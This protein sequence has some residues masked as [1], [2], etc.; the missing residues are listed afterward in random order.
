MRAFL[1][2]I[3][4]W[5]SSK[6]VDLMDAHEERG[7]LR[8]LLRAATETDCGLP[9]DDSQLA[10]F[11]K[12]GAQWFKPTKEK[13]FRLGEKTSGQKLR[14]C[15]F[16]RDG[17]LFNERLLKEWEYQ[18]SISEKRSKASAAGNA[19][20]WH[21]ES[22]KVPI[23]IASGCQTHPNDVCVCVS[24][25]SSEVSE[26]NLGLQNSQ[27][28]LRPKPSPIRDE[29]W[30]E[31]RV[32]AESAGMSGSEPDWNEAWFFQWRV[33]SFEER[34]AARKGVSDRQ[35][36]DDPALKSLPQNY[37]QKRKWERKIRDPS[38][39]LGSNRDLE[40]QSALE[41]KMRERGELHGSEKRV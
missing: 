32:E 34:F 18:K 1:F 17:R 41:R 4:D 38:G 40:K 37:L 26:E 14:E 25:S 15:F 27:R 35:G 8:L 7:Y 10:V 21:K 16:V 30:F 13:D 11:S 22:D 23:D 12:L 20:R 33:M 9:D 39:S 3:D 5:L 29:D 24:G 19:K 36:K 28:S 31:F 6:K 2:Y